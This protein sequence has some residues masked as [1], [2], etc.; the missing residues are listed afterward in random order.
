MLDDGIARGQI[1]GGAVQGI[2][3]AMLERTVYDSRDGQLQSGS[4][5]D[6]AM[7][8]ADD[9]PAFDGAWCPE[10]DAGERESKGVGEVGAIGAPAAVVNAVA[11]A[12]GHQRIDMPVLA[13]TT[14]RAHGQTK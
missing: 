9:I 5:L 14:W 10:G 3:Q 4:F 2:G 8:R 12:L 6:Y 11:N 1:Q 7:P 13:E